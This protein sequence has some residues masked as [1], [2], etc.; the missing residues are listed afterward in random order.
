MSALTAIT[1]QNTQGVQ[2]VQMMPAEFVS[3]QLDSVLSDLGADVVKTGMLGTKDIVETTAAKFE[4]HGVKLLVVDPVMVS[5]SG[6]VLLQPDAV[7]SYKSRLIPLAT[8]ITP[9]I[10]EASHL[11]GF[12]VA[13]L[14]DMKRAASELHKMGPKWVLVKG[15]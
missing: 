15:G 8:V 4:Q 12:E 13:T 10:K 9:N 11:L 14:A 3:E 2:G 6:H 7:D 5:T 1:A